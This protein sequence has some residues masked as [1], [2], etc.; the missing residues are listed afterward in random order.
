MLITMPD[1]EKNAASQAVVRELSLV[2]IM[3]EI[4]KSMNMTRDREARLWQRVEQSNDEVVALDSSGIKQV[5]EQLRLE[6]DAKVQTVREER[7][8]YTKSQM[9]GT[10]SPIKKMIL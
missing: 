5:T 6:T 7:P 3:S 10:G 1:S 2:D 8:F 9:N 4:Q